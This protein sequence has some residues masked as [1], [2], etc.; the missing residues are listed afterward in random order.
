MTSAVAEPVGAISALKS[1]MTAAPIGL[2]PDQ[3]AVGP[4]PACSTSVTS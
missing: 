1:G 2:D 3:A 4:A